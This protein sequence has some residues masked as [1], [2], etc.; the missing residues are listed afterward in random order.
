[1]LTKACTAAF[2]LVLILH[3]CDDSKPVHLKYT[4]SGGKP[5]VLA[6]YEA[7]FGH[8][9]H[10]QVGYSSN[11]PAEMRMQIAEA[12]RMGI[13]GFVVDWYGYRSPYINRNYGRMQK[14]AARAGFN[15]A[16][17]Y[18]QAQQADGATDETIAEL[19]MFHKKYLTKNAPGRQAY[20]M[21]RGHPVIFVFPHGNSTNWDEVRAAVNQWNP[22]PFLIDENLPGKYGKDFDGFYPWI[23][24]G[25][26]GWAANGSRW[27]AQYLRS[28]YTTMTEKFEDKI[29]VDGAWPRFNDKRASWSLD[30]HM[31]ARCGQTLKDTLNFW[32]KYV[33]ANQTIPFVL[34]ETWNDYEEGSDIEAGLPACGGRATPRALQDFEVP[35]NP[36]KKQ[37]RN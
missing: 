10:I 8:P 26:K 24:P 2:L 16:M 6:V 36:A 3:G 12:R 4:A 17:M 35:R 25:P 13:S 23:N 21:Y 28:F 7:W 5:E 19:K 18:D 29:I 32:K 20:L 31:N 9:N 33:P 15:V 27:G 30:R 34:I 11:N 14:V 22:R 37:A 1:M